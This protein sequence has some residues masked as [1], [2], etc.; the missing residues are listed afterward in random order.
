MAYIKTH[1]NYVLKKRHRHVSNDR[2]IF[3]RDITT[4][5]GLNQFAPGQI[6]IYKSGNFIITVNNENNASRHIK[7][8]PWVENREG[9]VWDAGNVLEYYD[10]LAGTSNTNNR[11]EFRKDFYKLNEFAYYGSLSELVRTSLEEIIKTFPGEL[12]FG[13]LEYALSGV[14]SGSTYDANKMPIEVSYYDGAVR[15]KLGKDGYYLV[16]N[17]FGIDVHTTYLE[18]Y[19]SY[20]PIKYFVN[21]G[22][23]QFELIDSEDNH[24]DITYEGIDMNPW[25]YLMFDFGDSNEGDSVNI[26]NTHKSLPIKLAYSLNEEISNMVIEPGECVTIDA[27]FTSEYIFNVTNEGEEK[28]VIRVPKEGASIDFDVVSKKIYD[29]AGLELLYAE[30]IYCKGDDLG[31]V[32]ITGTRY[33]DDT[34]ITATIKMHALVGDDYQIYYMIDSTEEDIDEVVINGF[35]IRPTSWYYNTFMSSLNDFERVLL[36]QKTNPR[37]K[38]VF[39]VTRENDNGYYT[40]LESFIYPVGLGGYNLGSYGEAYNSYV[41]SLVEVSSWY[42]EMF[43]DNLFRSMTHESIK[44]LDW[45]FQREKREDLAELYGEGDNKI[46]SF[47]RIAGAE[48]DN[49]KAFIDNIPTNNAITYKGNGNIPD[50][51]VS[52]SLSLDGWDVHLTYPFKLS[53]FKVWTES[54]TTY[55]EEFSGETPTLDEEMS[56]MTSGGEKIKRVFAQDGT[57]SV[58]PYSKNNIDN[59]KRNGYFLLCPS[60]EYGDYHLEVK[61]SS[62]VVSFDGDSIDY[63]VESY[64]EYP[65]PSPVPTS[66]LSTMIDPCTGEL[67]RAMYQYSNES[68]FSSAEANIEFERRLKINS[69]YILRSKGNYN[70]LE[71][72]LG[73]F[74]MKSKR[75]YEALPDI[76]K[77]KFTSLSGNGFPYDYELIEYTLFSPRINERWYECKD[78]YM[79]SWCNSTKLIGYPDDEAL[80]DYDRYLGLPV[81]IVEKDDVYFDK[82]LGLSG[83]TTT[84][85]ENAARFLNGDPVKARYLY[86]MFDKSVKHDGDPHYQMNGGW[87]RIE[88]IKFDTE[89]NILS[90]NVTDLFKETVQTTKKVEFLE[91]LLQMPTQS[92]FDGQIFYV[93]YLYEDYGIIDGK[94]YQLLTDENGNKYMSFDVID[95]GVTIGDAYFDNYVDTSNPYVDNEDK[96]LRITLQDKSDGYEIRI[97]V[98]DGTIKAEAIDVVTYTFVK[99]EDGRYKDDDLEYTHYFR[100]NDKYFSNEISSNGWEQIPTTD[101]DYYKLSSVEDY[102]N[103]NN[104]HDGRMKYDNGREYLTYFSDLFK[105]AKEDNCALIDPTCYTDDDIELLESL[106][107]KDYNKNLYSMDDTYV[108]IPIPFGFDNLI[109]VGNDDKDYDRYLIED[110]KVCFFGDIMVKDD[111]G[112]IS[113]INYDEFAEPNSDRSNILISYG[114]TNYESH[115][116]RIPEEDYTVDNVTNQIVNTKR[117]EIKFY[118]KSDKEVNPQEYLKE[119]KYLQDVVLPYAEQMI[120]SNMIWTARFITFGEKEYIDEVYSKKDFNDSLSFDISAEVNTAQTTTSSTVYDIHATLTGTVDTYYKIYGMDGVSAETN[121]FEMDVTDITEIGIF[122]SEGHDTLP[123]EYGVY[124]RPNEASIEVYGDETYYPTGTLHLSK[125]TIDGKSYD[126]IPA[127]TFQKDFGPISNEQ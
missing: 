67:R 6:P 97:Y 110:D 24:Y 103:G 39:E 117:M 45:S 71:M 127:I 2:T 90:K 115:P 64:R 80:L 34:E 50:Y 3:E 82:D 48:F 119:V 15:Q 124:L 94:V 69:R 122:G 95:H 100:I 86:P 102:Y 56:N 126:V 23:T 89:N 74:G 14:P 99:F 52:D 61:P 63:E 91:E 44:N 29:I 57:I 9:D 11:L 17:P 41:N 62:A 73:L 54:G 75:W 98:V 68:V 33:E 72:L 49:V 47:I 107:K 113:Y 83:V 12:F 114:G 84:S 60:C 32:T 123:D 104:P 10:E 37:Y 70:G 27:G 30:L 20:S 18:D 66:G 31:V 118:L 87:E 8:L 53:E 125:I 77:E 88:P 26:C 55:E 16:S 81:M 111:D 7:R 1:S 46:S 85:E 19:S 21:E 120:P 105:Y 25:S 51:L 101:K 42:D 28:K 106:E 116:I 5:G 58:K 4:I 79:I 76:S 78:N 121:S 96:V 36:S 40:R 109:P 108:S 59:I 65:I 13:G 22:Y 35:H 112:F 43:T 93:R 38:A 92:L